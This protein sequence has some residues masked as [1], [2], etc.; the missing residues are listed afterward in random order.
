MGKVAPERMPEL[1]DKADV[2]INASVI[3]NMPLSIIEAFAA[4]LAVVTT[5]AGGIPYIVEDGRNGLLA[6]CGD[7]QSL[8]QAVLRLFDE[9]G[10][11]VRLAAA[12]RARLRDYTWAAVRGEWLRLYQELA[13]PSAAGV[14]AG[15][16]VINRNKTGM[17]YRDAENAK[18]T[19]RP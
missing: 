1:Y 8:A 11:A 14:S 10:L 6:R 4:G 12:A 9:P 13:N 2:F 3:D 19:Q 18:D 5:D 16:G 15:R 7:E 17:D